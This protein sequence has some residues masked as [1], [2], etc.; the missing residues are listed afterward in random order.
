MKEKESLA[1]TRR[2][3]AILAERSGAILIMMALLLPAF[4]VIAAMSVEVGRDYMMRSELQST[5]DAA[6]LAGASQ[7]ETSASAVKAQATAFAA[8]NMS[9]STYD[10]VLK[11]ADVEMG[12]WDTT[13]KKFTAG[14]TDTN[15]V[16]VT[17]RLSSTNSN[18]LTLFFG[19]VA[20]IS[21]SN[22]TAQAVAVPGGSTGNGCVLALDPN[23]DAG[24]LTVGGNGSI[25]NSGCGVFVNSSSSSALTCN[26]NGSISGSTSVVGGV[27]RAPN[28]S[29]SGSS[30]KTGASSVSDPYSSVSRTPPSGSCSGNPSSGSQSNPTGTIKLCSINVSG[31][32]TLTLA[33]GVY[34]VSG[35]LSVAGNGN[36]TATA[37]GGVTLIVSGA[38]SL[39]GNGSIAITAPSSGTF[40]GIA[41]MAASD[42]TATTSESIGGNG[43]LKVTGAIYFPKQT[44]TIAGNG[45][46]GS[47]TC[48]Q[49]IA[50]ELDFTGNASLQNNCAS[51]G[52]KSFG[53]SSGKLRL[54][55]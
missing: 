21:S 43:T 30:N 24:A 33:A 41:L 3:R 42:A 47:A 12:A 55:Q 40:A 23:N 31:N 38:V 2:L 17:T 20:K 35:G 25:S 51:T 52:V 44:L 26:G 46:S 29:L 5:A 18:A 48:T 7:I 14:G 34:Y 54:V 10:S 1:W 27:S 50:N 15:A 6:A 11:A 37:S 32:N 19:K 45:T 9:T 36:L 8:R 22:I 4:I 49:I 53:G 39:A 16:R 13:T 28:C